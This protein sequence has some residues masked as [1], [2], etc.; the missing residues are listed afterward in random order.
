MI[1]RV[2]QTDFIVKHEKAPIAEKG[3]DL[4]TLIKFIEILKRGKCAIDRPLPTVM[5][6][7]VPKHRKRRLP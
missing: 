1:E 5:H 2:D 7:A 3:A 4:V 6:Q